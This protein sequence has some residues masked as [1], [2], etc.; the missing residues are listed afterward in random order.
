MSWGFIIFLGYL[1]GFLI[2]M[3]IVG[4]GIAWDS[5]GSRD[6]ETMDY[7]FGLLL[8]GMIAVFWPLTLPV[9]LMVQ[10]HDFMDRMLGKPKD[11]EKAELQQRIRELEQ[12]IK[13]LDRQRRSV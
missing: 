12:N 1:A 4:R 3:R 7:V 11:V 10:H 13:N 5:I 2:T 9:A 8:G 6:P